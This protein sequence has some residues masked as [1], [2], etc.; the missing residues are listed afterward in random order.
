MV[1]SFV[2]GHPHEL[3]GS[4]LEHWMTHASAVPVYTDGSKSDEGVGSSAVFPSFEAFW[5]L[6]PNRL[7]LHGGAGS[8]FL[9]PHSSLL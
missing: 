6:P 5:F 2:K 4:T 3:R 1:A 9:S 8:H 7:C